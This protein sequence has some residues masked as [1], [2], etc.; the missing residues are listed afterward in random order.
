MKR[1][2]VSLAL[3][4]LLSGAVPAQEV[5]AGPLETPSTAEAAEPPPPENVEAAPESTEPEPIGGDFFF[6]A[7]TG[8]GLTQNSDLRIQQPGL[9][10][11][12]TFQ[13]VGWDHNSFDL[14]PYYGVRIGYFLEDVPWLGVMLDY[15]H[16]KVLA[17]TPN[18]VNIAGTRFGT[19]FAATAPMNTIVQTFDITN[20]V[21][22]ISFSALARMQVDVSSEFPHGRFQPYV[23]LGLG[24][25]LNYSRNTVD[26][27]AKDGPYEWGNIHVQGFTGVSYL[28]IPEVDVFLE[29]KFN[30]TAPTVTTAAGTGSTTL[31]THHILFGTGYHW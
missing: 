9:G 17:Q 28:I 4:G 7:Y 1:I 30:H 20:G 12:L 11:D 15:T 24:P 2:L 10:N 21:S 23:G 8:V 5:P 25:T 22:L 26:F 19:P 6:K 27:A 13:G 14:A 16:Y 31:N 29:Y 3:A 18:T